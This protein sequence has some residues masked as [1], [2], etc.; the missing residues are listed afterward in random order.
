LVDDILKE[1]PL[2]PHSKKHYLVTLINSKNTPTKLD[3]SL[4]LDRIE[5]E[6]YQQQNLG[7]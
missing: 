1:E 2:I 6:N 5:D 7:F 4:T 3:G